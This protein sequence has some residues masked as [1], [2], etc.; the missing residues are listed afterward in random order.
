VATFSRLTIRIGADTVSLV[1]QSCLGGV[2]EDFHVLWLHDWTFSFFISYKNV[3]LMI[4]L[5][6]GFSGKLFCVHFML[7]RNGGLD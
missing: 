7:W 2:A 1:L 6:R 5:L 3:G 4:H